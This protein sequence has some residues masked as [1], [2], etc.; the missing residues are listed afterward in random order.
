MD[1]TKKS[2]V[3]WLKHGIYT[4]DNAGWR[5]LK[6]N[7]LC[8]Q[9]AVTKG[10]FYHWFTSKQDYEKQV[11]AYWKLLFTQDF[12]DKAEQGVTSKE[13]LSL[14]CRQCIE[15]VVL[16]TRLEFEINAWSFH[17]KQVKA[18]VTSVYEERHAYLNHLLLNIYDE[19]IQAKK[20]GLILYSLVIGVD[21]FYRQLT[22]DELELILSDYL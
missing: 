18:F 1:S 11:L 20:H 17:D 10:S 12:I 8:K 14:L 13:K 2:K 3:A 21:L 16:G 6:V 4:L 5:G 15:G 9:L 7:E 19:P 22:I